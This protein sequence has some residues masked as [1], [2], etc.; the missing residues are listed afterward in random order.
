CRG[1]G[2]LR[3]IDRFSMEMVYRGPYHF[4]VACQRGEATDP[5]QYLAAQTDLGVVKHTRK[6]RKRQ[7]LD[8]LLHELIL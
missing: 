3:A 4:T 2:A 5:V 6:Y 8:K 7:R 1:R